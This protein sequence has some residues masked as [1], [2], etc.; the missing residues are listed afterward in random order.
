VIRMHLQ[1]DQ[2]LPLYPAKGCAT[3]SDCL[4]R[5]GAA[6]PPP[7]AS[8]MH[9]WG[10]PATLPP[11]PQQQHWT[12]APHELPK[13]PPVAVAAHPHSMHGLSQEE[14]EF[15]MLPTEGCVP[16]MP[17]TPGAGS[18]SAQILPTRP[19]QIPAT[20][21]HALCAQPSSEQEARGAS[22]LEPM[23][24]APPSQPEQT[25]GAES[26]YN[27]SNDPDFWDTVTMLALDPVYS[28]S[29]N[30]PFGEI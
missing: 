10:S 21:T 12:G 6:A 27:Q 5:P 18:F 30:H 3:R 19:S 7:P 4:P 29:Y 14:Q 26:H 1:N 17:W 25:T 2:Q 20:M 24:Q 23:T 28:S 15:F 9:P 8:A 13:P 22:V 16:K 11:P